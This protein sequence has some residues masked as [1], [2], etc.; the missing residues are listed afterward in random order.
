MVALLALSGCMKMEMSVDIKSDDDVRV[1]MMVGMERSAAEAMADSGAGEMTA[2]DLCDQAGDTGMGTD[3]V[4][5]K[6]VSDDTYIACEMTGTTD[7]ASMA[8]SLQHADGKYTFSMTSDQEGDSSAAGLGAGMFDSFKVSVTFPGK[9]L[10]HNG[11][12]TVSGTTVTWTDPNDMYSPEGLR[13]V[14]EDTSSSSSNWLWIV[15]AVVAVLVVVVVAVVLVVVLRG[16]GSKGS[17]P[18]QQYPQPYPQSGP[19]EQQPYPQSGPP[20]QPPAPPSYPE[21]PPSA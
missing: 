6:D 10:E 16:R 8:D 11:S 3:D 18:A 4:T 14:G 13:A 5:V 7:L 2:D 19:P 12:S 9:V 21:Q 20:E 17:V 15:L 1:K